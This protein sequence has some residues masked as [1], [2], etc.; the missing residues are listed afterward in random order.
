MVHY[1]I[2]ALEAVHT[3][4]PAFTLPHPHTHILT[5]YQRTT[6]ADLPAR[7][8]DADIIIN[9]V[10]PL[11][12]STLSAENTPRLKLIACMAS[13]TDS[14]DLAACRARGIRVMNCPHANVETVAEHALG[15]YFAA[16]RSTVLVQERMVGVLGDGAEWREKE[17]LTPYMRTNG[18]APM[19]CQEEVVGIVGAGA[20]GKYFA[21]LAG[22]LGMKVLLSGRKGEDTASEGRTPFAEVLRT[23]T[24][25][26]LSLPRNPQTLNL[27]SSEEFKL[28]RP[29]AVLV[30]VSRGGIVNEVDLVTALREK[31]IA[32]AATDVFLKEPARGGEEADNVLLSGEARGLN[33]TVS[34]HVA[35]Y[36]ER[37]LTN[38]R[39]ILK[40]NI[41]GWV[42]GK[43]Q[44]VV[45]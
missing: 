16:R 7:V 32:G 22:L 13:G 38:Y 12:A 33:L 20:V 30:N 14:I 23:A 40:E 8:H 31:Q 29:E 28:M 41:E 9:V 11:T 34:P 25:I 21:K 3:P 37:T 27:L 10:Q 4:M 42:V 19:G 44:N 43:E 35:W 36:G 26:L 24:V 17:T 18:R 45:V 1:N 5:S 6:A 2:V 15:L 39:R